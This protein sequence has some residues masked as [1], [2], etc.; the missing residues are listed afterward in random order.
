M[1]DMASLDVLFAVNELR[2]LIGGQVQKI[3]Q[4]GKAIRLMIFVPEKGS[5]ELYFEPGKIFITEYKRKAPE[6][7]APFCMAL[8]KHLLGQRITDIRQHG[9]DRIVE[10]EFERSILIFELFSKGNVILCDRAYT[11]ILPLEVQIWRDRQ[12]L[13]KRAYQYPPEIA[14][15]FELAQADLKKLLSASDK[16]I[17]RFLAV[18]LG[19]SG[20]YAEEVCARAL[21][22]KTKLCKELSNSELLALYEAI[23]S[24]RKQFAPQLVFDDSKIIDVVPFDMKIYAG[25]RVRHI[26]TFMHALDEVYTHKETLEAEL[27]K[28]RLAETRVKKLERILEKQK[29]DVRKW[30]AL[31]EES[32]LKAEAIYRNFELVQRI[33][34]GL[35]KAREAGLSWQQIKDKIAT[36]ETAEARAITEIKEAKGTVIVELE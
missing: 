18:D 23:H 26:P 29:A 17:V 6:I 10:L 5:F 12:I 31:E 20:L 21:I 36:E 32:R 1:R 2:A 11:I 3:Y 24:L 28:K 27:E 15:P 33:I 35:R 22:D 19:L 30:R 9:F 8:R 25:R 7:P 14:N 16:D 13:P 34:S 4:D